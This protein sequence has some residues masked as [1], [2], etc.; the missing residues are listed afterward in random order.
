MLM[1]YYCRSLTDPSVRWES[2]PADCLGRMPSSAL[3]GVLLR[4]GE[5]VEWHFQYLP[6]G[7]RYVTGYTIHRE[8]VAVETED[9][10]C[11]SAS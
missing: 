10:S 6:D 9:V 1:G 2:V 4:D 7:T 5:R 8:P 11:T 3:A